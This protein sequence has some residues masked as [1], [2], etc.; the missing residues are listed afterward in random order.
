MTGFE[1]ER[2]IIDNHGMNNIYITEIRGGLN[3]LR[4]SKY[5]GN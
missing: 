2:E 5:K 1:V 3:K 4:R